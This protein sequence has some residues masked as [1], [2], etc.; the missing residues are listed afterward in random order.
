MEGR[1][2]VHGARVRGGFRELAG[3]WRGF[4]FS[5]VSGS[6]GMAQITGA[7]VGVDLDSGLYN[8]EVK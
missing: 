6:H 2:R 8:K 7:V 5:R 1:V 3:A 4:G